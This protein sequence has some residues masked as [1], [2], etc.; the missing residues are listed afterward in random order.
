VLPLAAALL[1]GCGSDPGDQRREQVAAV[2][3]AANERDAAGVRQGADA[4]LRTI[5]DQRGTAGLSDAE[6]DRLTELVRS[7]RTH[8]DVVDADL[9]EQRKAQA[10]AEAER[11][12]L[13][14]ERTR[15]EE[16]RRK[17]EEAARQ[18]EEA[19]RQAEERDAGKGKGDDREKDEKDDEDD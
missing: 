17:A 14:Q 12:R 6:A 16:E 18:A 10:D 3:G 13:A 19:A 7:V 15:L 11:T 1:G 2:L 5:A 4:L 8:A 9:L